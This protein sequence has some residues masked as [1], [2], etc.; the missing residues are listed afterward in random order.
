MR[1]LLITV[2]FSVFFSCF[3]GKAQSTNTAGSLNQNFTITT[4]P[5]T[6]LS[7]LEVRGNKLITQ[8]FQNSP[9]GSQFTGNFTPDA[10]WNSMGSLTPAIGSPVLL[11]GFRTQTDGRALTMG[12]STSLAL[13]S[14]NILNPSLSN[15]FIEWIGNSSVSPTLTPGNLDFNYATQ[16]TGGQR[17]ATFT[18][19]PVTPTAPFNFNAF[20]YARANCL[21]GQLQSGVYGGLASTDKWV[22]IGNVTTNTSSF[23]GTRVQSNGVNIITGI[24]NTNL[25]IQFSAGSSTVQSTIPAGLKFK[26]D[27][28]TSTV[29]EIMNIDPEGRIDMGVFVGLPTFTIPQFN[30]NLA[31]SG[32]RAAAPNSTSNDQIGV[33][34]FARPSSP[35][36]TQSGFRQYAVYAD[37]DGGNQNGGV[38]AVF[39]NVNNEGANDYSGNFNGKVVASAYIPA[40]D[41]RLKKDIKKEESAIEKIMLLKPV[42]YTY[43]KPAS[44]WMNL[45]YSKTSHGFIADEVKEVFP[46]MVNEFDEPVMGNAKELQVAK[47]FKA[48]N[49]IQLISV[50][51]KGMQ[52]QQAE[53]TALKNALAASRTV[54]LSNKTDLPAEIE[55]KAFSLSQNVPNPFSERTTISYSIPTNVTKAVLAVFDLNGRMLQQYNL[56]QGKNQL[57]I[58][59]NSFGAGMYIYSL[60]ADGQEVV[61]KRMVLTK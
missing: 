2:Y 33:G 53:I 41:K 1:S 46:E 12:F 27:V 19:Q 13:P 36:S 9:T 58:N 24:E 50:L 17:V 44:K 51:T 54:V 40:S 30:Y 43:D 8:N 26:G 38:F 61:S 34:L 11:N 29:T 57:T 37:A 16:P 31:V 47:K 25:F 4:S 14:G 48:V 15:P 59:G 49:Y 55:N 23:I 32:K 7:E 22:G 39:C 35:L 28:G 60:I 10:R 21:L 56:L 20:A 6:N 18:I 42:S 5:N 52:E 45:E 3:F